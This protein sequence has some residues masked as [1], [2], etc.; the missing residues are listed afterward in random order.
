LR[1]VQEVLAELKIWLPTVERKVEAQTAQPP[2]EF[3][4]LNYRVQKAFTRARQ[5]FAD[6]KT[7]DDDV[8]S[9]LADHFTRALPPGKPRKSMVFK[10]DPEEP[11]KWACT[12]P[13]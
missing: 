12:P 13:A 9:E 1:E 2:S 4:K 11:I 10:Y 6:F 3:K 7:K 8:I 5:R